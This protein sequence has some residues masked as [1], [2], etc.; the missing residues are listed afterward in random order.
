[1]I[2]SNIL[3]ITHINGIL[4][5]NMCT[6]KFCNRHDFMNHSVEVCFALLVNLYRRNEDLLRIINCERGHQERTRSSFYMYVWNS[7]QRIKSVKV[8][9]ETLNKNQFS[10]FYVV[11][12]F[13]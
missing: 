11:N 4:F 2:K 10:Y 9:V 7:L 13:L 6:K 3:N 12:L 1:M 8:V 5:T